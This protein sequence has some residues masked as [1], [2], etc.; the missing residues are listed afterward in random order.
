MYSSVTEKLYA[1][2]RD[3]GVTY[4][5]LMWEWKLPKVTE[6]EENSVEAALCQ[7]SSPAAYISL[8]MESVLKLPLTKQY[9]RGDRSL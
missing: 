8:W 5:N 4:F 7:A 1:D 3:Q 6:E 9:S 2:W